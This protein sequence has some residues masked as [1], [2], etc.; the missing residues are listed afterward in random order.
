MRSASQ[1]LPIIKELR[2]LRLSSA[3]KE[4][5]E[6]IKI[7]LTQ[8]GNF[9]EQREKKGDRRNTNQQFSNSH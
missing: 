6:E 7:T 3:L 4:K 5:V 8:I 9:L 2:L 1:H